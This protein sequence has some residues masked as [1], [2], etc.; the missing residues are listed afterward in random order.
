M[1]GPYLRKMPWTWW[2]KRPNYTKFM[3]REITAVFVA[4]YLVCLLL[5]VMRLPEGAATMDA[6]F[7][8]LKSPGWITFHV[9]ALLF[10]L[11]HTITWFNLTPQV[12][13]IWRGE[14]KVPGWLLAGGNYVAWIAVSLVVGWILLS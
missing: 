14:E 1:S 11:Y 10:S 3:I 13:V 7:E 8:A 2:L 4:L 6:H 5:F 12:M 9:V